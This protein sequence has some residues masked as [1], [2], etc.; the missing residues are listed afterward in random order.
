VLANASSSRDW[1]DPSG[2]DKTFG[3]WSPWQLQMIALHNENEW[4]DDHAII[5]QSGTCGCGCQVTSWAKR[6]IC[7][8][9]GREVY[10][11]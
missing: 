2:K 4:W 3:E 1:V 7:P 9:C 5:C 11:T 6:A 8:V 10:L